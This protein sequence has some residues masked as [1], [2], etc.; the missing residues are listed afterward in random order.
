MIHPVQHL[1]VSD[2]RTHKVSADTQPCEGGLPLDSGRRRDRMW[3]QGEEPCSE[4]AYNR[5]GE[6]VHATG[7]A[8][9]ARVPED[10]G[11]GSAAEGRGWQDSA[12]TNH[13][14]DLNHKSFFSLF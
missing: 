1:D 14:S 7:G 10:V 11:P 3:R 5:K 13:K 4:E 6:R 8:D 2:G 12:W 9:A